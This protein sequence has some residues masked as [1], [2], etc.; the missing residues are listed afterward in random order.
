MDTDEIMDFSLRLAGLNRIPE[1]SAIYNNGNN[2]KKILFGL[3]ANATELLLA[4][5]LGFD[6]VISHHPAGGTAIIDHYQVF[7]R[8]IGQ[9]IS[10][11][12]PEH[13]ARKAVERK[14][15]QLEADSHTRNYN[16]AV[17]V[18]KL[19]KMPYMN[20]HTPL[21][22]VGRKIMQEQIDQNTNEKSKVKEVISTLNK[23]PE[24]RKAAT[25]IKLR[26][27]K[28]DNPIGKII[29]SHG[30][31]TNGGYDVAKTYFEHGVN[32]LIYI[33]VGFPDL[34]RLMNDDMGNLI[35]T[36]HIASDSVGINPFIRELEKQ[37]VSIKTLGVVR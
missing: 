20:I 5:Q 11:G 6:A 37:G 23:L 13:V 17:D 33:H 29:V 26:V 18:A 7:K 15:G 22:E 12:I 10:A 25:K 2:I 9:M 35:I 24:F 16:H 19:L 31:G 34:E 36:G 1:D 3:D 32:T 30:A 14:L 4:H 8:H 28:L 21:D 27:G